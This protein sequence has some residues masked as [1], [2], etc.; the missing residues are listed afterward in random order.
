VGKWK[1]TAECYQR[2]LEV[3]ELAEEFHQ[4]LM[5]CYQ[6]LGLRAEGM[7]A[8][9]RCREV[10]SNVLGVEPSSKTEAIYRSLK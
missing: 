6:Q 2:G 10:L 1:D 3:D 8:Y 5:L 9:R 7:A 4:R